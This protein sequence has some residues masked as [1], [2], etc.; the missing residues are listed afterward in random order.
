MSAIATDLDTLNPRLKQVNI[1][2]R[3]TR[4]AIF[5]EQ[6]FDVG[7]RFEGEMDLSK[8]M[9]ACDIRWKLGVAGAAQ[10]GRRVVLAA[11]FG[12]C[13]PLAARGQ[14]VVKAV[15]EL[16]AELGALFACGRQARRVADGSASAAS[17]AL[18]VVSIRLHSAN[19]AD[20]HDLERFLRLL[21]VEHWACFELPGIRPSEKCFHVLTV[22]CV[23]FCRRSGH[24]SLR[25]SFAKPQK[26]SNGYGMHM[27]MMSMSHQFA[28]SPV[29]A[30][31]EADPS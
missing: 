6:A 2:D 7:R 8:A 5:F 22:R 28:S 14:R 27:D 21:H 24:L 9:N 3:I 31:G 17:C 19:V 20:L 16:G 13:T 12:T 4:A 1:T 26:P 23:G 18:M 11:Q 30:L 10:L 29:Q 25:D 15:H